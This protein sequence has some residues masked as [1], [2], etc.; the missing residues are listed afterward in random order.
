MPDG[1]GGMFDI[2]KLLEKYT[3]YVPEIQRDYAHGRNH[4][5]ANSIRKQFL[6]DIY[7]VL[8]EEKTQLV[9]N[10]IYGVPKDDGKI[11]LI[12]GQQRVT[13]LFLLKYYL[14]VKANDTDLGFMAKLIYATRNSS[15][16]FC[17]F[18]KENGA[19]IKD[20]KD[21]STP[22]EMIKNHIMFKKRWL[23]DA[24][25]A[26]MLNMLDA[27]DQKE[28]DDPEKLYKNIDKIRFSF[29]ALDGFNV[30]RINDLYTAM[31]SHGKQLTPFEMIKGELLKKNPK[32]AAEING[33]WLPA[34]WE[35]AKT[36]ARDVLKKPDPIDHEKYA[37]KH[38]DSFLYHYYSF[39][40]QMIWWYRCPDHDEANESNGEH[41]PSVEEITKKIADSG[42][43]KDV[44]Y[45]MDL[46]GALSEYNFEDDFERNSVKS[47]NDGNKGKNTEKIVLFDGQPADSVQFFQ[48]C[49]LDGEES[50][51]GRRFQFTH[52]GRCY[53][54]AYVKYCYDKDRKSIKR[55]RTLEDYYLLM[56]ALYMR[57][58][59]NVTPTSVDK[60]NLKEELIG[61]DVVI[62]FNKITEMEQDAGFESWK[63]DHKEYES[64]YKTF[65]SD[66]KRKFEVLNNPLVR[67]V[68]D[69]IGDL[70]A[71]KQTNNLADNLEWLL[72][73][74]DDDELKC[75][76]ALATC[77]FSNLKCE[78]NGYSDRLFL[79]FQKK[80]LQSVFSLRG[81][82]ED[83]KDSKD[84]TDFKEL[85]AYLRGNKLTDQTA[86][87]YKPSPSSWEY[88]YITYNSFRTG[89]YSQ[90]K[91][92]GKTCAER[93]DRISFDAELI[94][95]ERAVKG[96]T[97]NPFLY[98]IICQLKG[99]ETISYNDYTEY[100]NKFK[101]SFKMNDDG[102]FEWKYRGKKYTTDAD[103]DC[104]EEFKKIMSSND[105]KAHNDSM[106]VAKRTSD[107]EKKDLRSKKRK[108]DRNF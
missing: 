97:Y 6:Q 17:E 70:T 1:T 9:L 60:L 56:R 59:S 40:V 82:I 105:R 32:L 43:M 22:S 52:A 102:R 13:T 33:K 54:W 44:V 8:H 58:A 61:R 26:N 107:N 49:C 83:S 5:P 31:N 79:P 50:R 57:A 3:V 87:D 73:A 45:A 93:K 62:P 42:A 21:K 95:N 68:T 4:E 19:C 47:P 39:I 38:H 78:T 77:G 80:T 100:T 84:S 28:N 74:A 66:Y 7:A 46:V 48:L 89:A 103:K 76:K 71:D 11:I 81:W 24:T 101:L 23:K 90:F 18:L 106:A 36:Y 72:G 85:L 64:Q 65:F 27:I 69:N 96:Q 55:D 104:I 86:A 12:D 63:N 30:R 20:N 37:A 15:S 35:I 41:L 34:F 25:V 91:M 51:D 108:K 67:G 99:I 92:P 53:L 75:F 98:E 29:I 2:S 10:Y 88:Y 14:A 94:K 16:E